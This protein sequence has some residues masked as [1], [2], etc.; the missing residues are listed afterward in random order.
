MRQKLRAAWAIVMY[1]WLFNPL[2]RRYF[3]PITLPFCL[4]AALLWLLFTA[5]TLPLALVATGLV[6]GIV[7]P[8]WYAWDRSETLH[9]KRRARDERIAATAYM[10]ERQRAES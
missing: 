2:R 6:A 3:L 1:I 10:R 7:A 5:L 9:D 4:I 8:I